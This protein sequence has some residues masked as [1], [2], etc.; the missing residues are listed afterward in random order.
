VVVTRDADIRLAHAR[1]ASGLEL[2]PDEVARVDEAGEVVELVHHAIDART[3]ITPA[4]SQT[5]MTGASI[6][7][8]G[9]LLSLLPMNDIIDVDV[10]RRV[11]RVEPGVRIGELNAE[12]AESGLMFAPDPT[13]ENDAT[14]GGA[15]ALN[16]SGARSLYYGA[17]RQHVAGITVVHAD[18]EIGRYSR[19]RPEKNTVGYM[20]VQDPVDW[21]VG[22]EG[23]LGIVVEAEL[24]LVDVPRAPVGLAIPFSSTDAALAFVVDARQDGA[25]RPRCL[26]YFD[27]EAAAIA[28]AVDG[29]VSRAGD[30]MIYLE[31]DAGRKMISTS[32][33]HTGSIWPKCT[34]P[35]S[36]TFGPI[37]A[38]RP[39]ERRA[40]CGMRFRRR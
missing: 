21:F 18:G 22:S 16:A 36:L 25:R 14:V 11:A 29:V 1:D 2:V 9:L 28:G 27:V 20:M 26:E 37:R 35:S 31:D 38:R 24:S 40:Q 32:C 12:L 13:S 33:W 6:T 30:A 7:D 17:T 39:C 8:S 15:I 3:T 10:E 19:F 34:M 5:S 23:T 4:G